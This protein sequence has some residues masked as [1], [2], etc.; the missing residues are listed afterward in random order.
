MRPKSSPKYLQVSDQLVSYFRENNFM[1]G[2]KLPTEHK[3][4]EVFSVSRTT[5]R[6]ALRIL[7]N[8]GLIS[9][10]QGSGTFFAGSRNKPANVHSTKT[11]GLVNFFFIDYIYTE[12]LKG[13]EEEANRSGY[14]LVIC[15]SDR[16]DA[17]QYDAIRG[18]INQGIDGLILE[19]SYTIQNRKDHPIISLLETA[20][21]PVVTTHRSIMNNSFSSVVLDDIYA[22][23]MAAHYLLGKGHKRIGFVH[24][25]D[26][27]PYYDRYLG[28]SQVLNKAGYPLQDKYCYPYEKIDTID[29]RLHGYA[30]TK[31]MI[32]E[33]DPAP[34]AVFYF[35]DQLAI[36]GYK[37]IAECGL[38]IPEDISVLGFDDFNYSAI[39]TPPL[40]TFSHP[41]YDL[42]KWVARILIDE[43]EHSREVMPKRM[44]FEPK[45]IERGSVAAI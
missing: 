40:T 24:K 10:N 21:I 43:I 14:S 13:I 16:N 33:N 28:F 17:K 8:N 29:N 23:E 39:V 30:M 7:E 2:D 9:R 31:R 25:R 12:I 20:G 26:V 27:Q 3:L 18:L 44:V 19:P 22:G 4:I 35:N 38:H 32:E 37:A 6:N 15:T 42:G 34:T 45:I 41:K 1:P 5:I 11:L 36:Q